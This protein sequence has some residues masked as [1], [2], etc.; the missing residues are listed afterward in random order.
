MEQLVL[1]LLPVK[2]LD[3]GQVFLD[4]LLKVVEILRDNTIQNLAFVC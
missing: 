4:V 2:I 1:A 3:L